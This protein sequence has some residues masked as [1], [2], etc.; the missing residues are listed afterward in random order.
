M[1]TDYHRWRNDPELLA[2]IKIGQELW[3]Q[4]RKAEKLVG[5]ADAI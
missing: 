1:K 3:R 5:A 2:H 4:A